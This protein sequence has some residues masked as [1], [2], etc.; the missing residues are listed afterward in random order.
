MAQLEA[1]EG[2]R[3]GSRAQQQVARNERAVIR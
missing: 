3:A 1:H 2:C